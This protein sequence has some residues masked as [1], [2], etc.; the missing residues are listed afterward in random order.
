M[1]LPYRS[2]QI[3]VEAVILKTGKTAGMD[4]DETR[5]AC[6]SVWMA[7]DIRETRSQ[8]SMRAR[9][10]REERRHTRCSVVSGAR[11]CVYATGAS[12]GR[13]PDIGETRSQRSMRARN[14]REERSAVLRNAKARSDIRPNGAPDVWRSVPPLF[15]DGYRGCTGAFLPNFNDSCIF[16]LRKVW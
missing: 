7:P 3:K 9:N 11:F 8:R 6:A 16:T 12:V 10:D 5:R 14:D 1:C 4:A 13:A 2:A 15:H